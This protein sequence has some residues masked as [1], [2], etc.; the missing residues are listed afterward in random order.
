M[1][2]MRRRR[3]FVG[4]ALVALLGGAAAAM[5]EN[6]PVTIQGEVIDPALY[7]RETRHGA[8][9][10][11]AI[12]DAVDAGQTLAILG[13]GTGTVYVLLASGPGEDPNDLAYEHIAHRV[14]AT[15]MVYERGG[16]K[17]IVLTSVESLEA[18]STK[19]A[20]SPATGQKP[21]QP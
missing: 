14:K 13:D 17:G 5:A 21:A 1:I 12:Y 3:R 18:P 8:D 15:G 9:A 4:I 2:A 11:D 6:A 16:L 19:T 7:L 10:E 20:G